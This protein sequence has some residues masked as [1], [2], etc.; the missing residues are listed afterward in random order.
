MTVLNRSHLDFERLVTREHDRCLALGLARYVFTI[1]EPDGNF[2]VKIV[3]RLS[4]VLTRR[5]LG[6]LERLSAPEELC[7][8]L[9]HVL[10]DLR[11][12][13][14]PTRT[15]EALVAFSLPEERAG[16][17][18]VLLERRGPLGVITLNRPKAL[19]ALSLPMIRAIEPQLEAWADEPE[20]AAV[21]ITGAGERA[22][23]AGG[24]IRAVYD[25]GLARRRGEAD[26]ADDRDFFRAEYTLNHR[27]H[28]YPKPFIAL[29]DGISMGGGV[30][31]SVHGSTRIVTERAM[32]AMPE[33]GIGLFPDVGGGWFLPTCPG[34]TGTYVGLTGVRCRAADCLYL[35]YATHYVP[36]ERLDAV[37]DALRHA[38]WVGA[39]GPGEASDVIERAL[40][41]LLAD[42]GLPAPLEELRPAIDRCFGH[43]SVEEILGALE[44]EGTAWADGTRSE[45]A[46]KSPVSL[47]TTLEQLR[48]GAALTY[49]QVVTM[50][51]RMS[52]ACLEDHDFYEGVRAQIVDKDRRPR[53]SPPTLREVTAAMV[54]RHFKPLGERDL[55][56]AAGHPGPEGRPAR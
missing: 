32:F 8:P 25:H 9:R 56:L 51:Y 34:E 15:V 7:G 4:E 29:V 13:R 19:N 22:F 10:P 21:L 28:R 42:P 27:I 53:W 54:D 39:G 38:A 24:D 26:E 49:E 36:S 35:G 2:A 6:R 40:A 12:D 45:L 46:G 48:R 20:V 52:Q 16:A 47:K 50:E 14:A 31:L 44:A 23:C 1:D 18:E 3:R 41:P 33:T 30:G 17:P 55:V 11:V 5:R 43:D 37:I